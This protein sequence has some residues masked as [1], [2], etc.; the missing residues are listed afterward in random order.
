MYEIHQLA[1]L[2]LFSD[3]EHGRPLSPV[4]ERPKAA[5]RVNRETSR[6]GHS[7]IAANDAVDIRDRMMTSACGLNSDLSTYDGRVLLV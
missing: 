1:I 2:M 6:C 5:K 7:H 4:S 3:P